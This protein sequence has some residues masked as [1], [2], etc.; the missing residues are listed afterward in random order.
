MAF[1]QQVQLYWHGTSG[2]GVSEKST[3]FHTQANPAPVFGSAGAVIDAMQVL[4]VGV[5][6]AK[7]LAPVAVSA[8]VPGAGPYSSANDYAKLFLRCAD[9]GRTELIIAAPRSDIWLPGGDKMDLAHADVQTLIAAAIAAV[10][11]GAGS[12][13]VAAEDGRRYKLS[14]RGL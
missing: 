4:S 6:K 5:V 1:R 12:P 2:N 7:R 10:S 8:G 14:V 13:V 3:T 11:N 9:G